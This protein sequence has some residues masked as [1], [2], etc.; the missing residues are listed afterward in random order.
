MQ[1]LQQRAVVVVVAVDHQAVQHEHGDF[2]ALG[3]EMIARGLEKHVLGVA[4]HEVEEGAFFVGHPPIGLAL[5][6]GL[7]GVRLEARRE[8]VNLHQRGLNAILDLGLVLVEEC[9]R[10]VLDLPAGVRGDQ[11][12]PLAVLAVLALQHLA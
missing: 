7:L 3:F 9:V 8:R 10:H 4:E 1:L 2:D 5:P 11:E 6:R 12:Q